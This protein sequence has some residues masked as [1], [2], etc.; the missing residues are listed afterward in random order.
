MVTL[1]L[2][3]VFLLIRLILNYFRDKEK[4]KQS[5]SLVVLE[6]TV[7]KEKGK[8]IEESRDPK[9]LA[10]LF[11]GEGE[12]FIASLYS[13]Y[14]KSK[15][16]DLASQPIVSFEIV[17]HDDEIIFYVATPKEHRHT[18]E[19]LIQS[20]YPDSLIEEVDGYNIFKP[21]S[22]VAACSLVL[23][24]Q[25]YY[26]IKTYKNLEVDP[27]NSITNAL[28]K[29]DKEESAAIQYIIRP[30]SDKWRYKGRMK[31]KKIQEGKEF[32]P[33]LA[34]RFFSAIG[35]FIG[36]FFRY[37]FHPGSEQGGSRDEI[38]KLTPLQEAKIQAL[39]E[40][41]NKV[42]FEANIRIVVSS[43]TPEKAKLQ[44]ENIK[45]AFSQ[46]TV[47]EFNGF[48]TEEIKS[49][50]EL[51]TNFIFR[52]FT[53][54]DNLLN[55]EELASIFHFPN[56]TIETPKI[57]WL[58]AKQA[59]PPPN[60]PREGVPLGESIYRGERRMIYMAEGPDRRR[61]VYII[62]KTG[63]G[64]S[65]LLAQMINYDIKTGKGVCVVDPNGDLIEDGVLPKIPRERIDDV[66]YFNPG[67]L[68]RP[69]GL[70]LFEWHR[71]EEK[72]F[73]IQELILMLYKLYD[74]HR[75]G[76]VGPLFEHWIRNAS[77]PLMAD[78]VGGTIIN[79]PRMFTDKN[80]VEEKLKYITDPNVLRF[81]REEMAQTPADR[82]GEIGGW[83]I[84]KFGAFM[85]NEMM[86]N[87][88][89]Q[90]KSGF[91]FREVMDKG[92]ILLC[93]LSKGRMGELNSALLGMILVTKIQ[94][95][96]MSRADIPEDERKDF[97]LYVDEFQNFATES[98]ITIL[99]EARKYHLNLIVANQFIGQ[100]P[101]EI[102]KAIFGNVGTLISFTIGVEDAEYMEK[103]FEPVFTR[104][105]L[106]NVPR[107][108]AYISLLIEG[109]E[110]RP[111]NMRT[112][113][114]PNPGDPQIKNSVIELSR[115]KYGRDRKIVE[116]EIF[117]RSKINLHQPEREMMRNPFL[118]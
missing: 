117:E 108:N 6:I 73:L 16:F 38:V 7:P 53:P 47:P 46:F 20:Y 106:I 115:L 105:D 102:K 113:K 68:E 84:A 100:L 39:E 107:F 89:G 17:A 31:A 60:M 14:R 50:Q 34:G 92:K 24:K 44:L 4:I 69:I 12:Q 101:D 23:A 54:N 33:T 71:P 43:S 67:D 62:G 93:N 18:V 96:A 88:M 111:F 70:N 56:Y 3:G 64:K 77:L 65:T 41:T 8:Q 5:L 55:A 94:M 61:H 63:T 30:V 59:P 118:K 15:I 103:E 1:F 13:L 22:K 11:V 48:K 110:S 36:D 35:S 28:S 9:E 75:Q 116:K 83:V 2:G 99:S 76:I 25:F 85:T 91:N 86:R 80:F 87:I 32:K 51:V 97:Y 95:A 45:S 40:K 42:G 37:L 109:T 66:I 72:D 21:E 104:K 58:L 112:I 82:K 19:Q 90:V 79:I 74:P 57:R 27:L 98:F 114:D 81:W 49:L 78:P 52:F 10:Q 26:P 29:L